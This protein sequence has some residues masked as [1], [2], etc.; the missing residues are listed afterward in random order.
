MYDKNPQRT[1]NREE[2]SQLHKKVYQKKSTV[3]VILYGE[4]LIFP[5]KIKNKA[6][7][8]YLTS[9]FQKKKGN[10]KFIG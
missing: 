6:R 9:P 8:F 4:K 3:N 7:T 1:R 10:K 2:L 5:A